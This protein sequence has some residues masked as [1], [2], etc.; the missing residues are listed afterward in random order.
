MVLG[1][2]GYYLLRSSGRSRRSKNSGG[3]VFLGLGLIIVGYVGTF[4]GNLIKAAVSRPVSYTHLRA[5]ET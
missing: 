4:F 2:I 5:H 1:I 3:I